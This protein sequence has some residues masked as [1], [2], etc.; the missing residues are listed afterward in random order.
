MPKK[1]KA[2]AS[3]KPVRVEAEDA[4]LPILFVRS[5]MT[6]DFIKVDYARDVRI[7][8]DVE[9]EMRKLSSRLAWYL[10]LRDVAADDLRDAKA[11]E[12]QTEEDL[13]ILFRDSGDEED[14][15]KPTETEVKTRVKAHHK[16][17]AAYAVRS[18]AESRLKKLESV[19]QALTEKRWML[20]S[21]VK[22]RVAEMGSGLG[23]A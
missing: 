7:G 4:A 17:R 8:S 23:E 6:G 16:M 18:E 14:K 9:A 12:Y 21:I 2:S 15:K 10:A 13:Y 19:I 11:V 20:T 22:L 3:K 1:E 5:P